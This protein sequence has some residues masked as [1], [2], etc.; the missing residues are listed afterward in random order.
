M[1]YA[2]VESGGKQ[3]HLEEGQEVFIDR[4]KGKE[5]EKLK[6]NDVLL[7]VDGD[8]IKIGQPKLDETT[9]AGTIM[10]QSKGKKI[11]VAV[12]KAKSR[13]RK[14]KGHRQAQTLVRIEQIQVGKSSKKSTK[15]DDTLPRNPRKKKRTGIS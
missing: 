12:Y 9:V 2:I 1:K 5:G 3:Y 4:I 8:L 10:A 13:Y 11:R 14:V 15:K 7:V 6:F